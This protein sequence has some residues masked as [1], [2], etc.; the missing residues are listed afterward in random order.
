MRGRRGYSKKL[1]EKSLSTGP[2]RG[3]SCWGPQPVLRGLPHPGCGVYPQDSGRRGQDARL[4]LTSSPASSHSAP[5]PCR[6]GPSAVRGLQVTVSGGRR[7]WV[8]VPWE[9]RKGPWPEPTLGHS[10]P[11]PGCAKS[12]PSVPLSEMSIITPSLPLLQ[13]QQ[14][15]IH[16]HLGRS[17]SAHCGCG[18]M[19]LGNAVGPA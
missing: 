7:A 9:G 12:L 16:R 11:P 17:A 18:G 5:D 14:C 4:S 2:R 6:I 3:G 10:Q 15:H 1:C 19:P 13:P 8:P